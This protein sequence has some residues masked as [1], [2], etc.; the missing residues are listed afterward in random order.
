MRYAEKVLLHN[1]VQQTINQKDPYAALS[2][3]ADVRLW[4]MDKQKSLSVL[5][6]ILERYINEFGI[7]VNIAEREILELPSKNNQDE[8]AV[9]LYHIQ[10]D[11]L[12]EVM[13]MRNKMIEKLIAIRYSLDLFKRIAKKDIVALISLADCLIPKLRDLSDV[14]E[15]LEKYD[16]PEYK[17]F[18]KSK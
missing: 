14:A 2:A 10:A 7:I 12:T 6:G 17:Q 4:F 15:L 5:D 18:Y 3:S 11:L 1:L 16:I 13:N 9:R 8:D